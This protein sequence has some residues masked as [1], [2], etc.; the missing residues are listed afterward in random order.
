MQPLNRAIPSSVAVGGLTEEGVERLFHCARCVEP[1]WHFHLWQ[2]RPSVV[3]DGV[4]FNLRVVH[5][6]PR[7]ETPTAEHKAMREL[8]QGKACQFATSLGL[9]SGLEYT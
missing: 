1:S 2:L 7:V 8:A 3:L 4:S 5:I 6:L 9:L